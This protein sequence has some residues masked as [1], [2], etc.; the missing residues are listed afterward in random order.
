MALPERPTSA[1]AWELRAV[2]A[3]RREVV[4]VLDEEYADLP[5]VQGPVVRVAVTPVA[6]TILDRVGEILV[7]LGVVLAVRRPHFTEPN[8]ER[9]EEVDGGG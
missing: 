2:W 8:D 9:K 3:T 4:L 5:R 7:P 1:V 6:A